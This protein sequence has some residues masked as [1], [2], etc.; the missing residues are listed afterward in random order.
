MQ[1][2]EPLVTAF[3]NARVRT[4]DPD[5]PHASALLVKDGLIEHVG[6]ADDIGAIASGATQVDCGGATV[7]PGFVDGHCHFE[8]TAVTTDAWINVHTPPHTSLAS[9]AG[10]I[11]SRIAN[12]TA[13]DWVLCRSSFAMHEKVVE[14]RLFNRHELDAIAADRP[15]AVFASLH[16]ASLNTV[17]LKRLALWEPDA[18]HPYHGLVHRDADGV[19]TGVVT[20]VFMMVPTPARGPAFDESV[21]RHARVQFNAA[22]TTS[23][24]TMPE[25]LD[26]IDRLRAL[27]R[28]HK[29]SLR[30]TYY[31]ISPGVANL[32]QA[33]ELRQL[34]GTGDTFR[35]GGVKVF[36]NGCG[37]DGL[38]VPHDDPKWTQSALNFF[39]RDAQS[40]G[41]QVWLHSLNPRGVRMAAEAI[42][43]ACGGGGN[44]LRHRIEHGGDFIDLAD[45]AA[46]RA[47]GAL[48][49]TTPQF[50]NSMTT[51]PTGPSAP[52]RTLRANGFRLIGGTDSTGTV[53]A[54]V[55]ILSNVATAATRRRH[56][57]TTFHPQEALDAESAVRL[58]TS[59]SSYGLHA[60]SRTGQLRKGMAADLVLVTDDPT[61]IPA[62]EISQV[63]VEATYLGGVQVWSSNV[64]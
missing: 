18:P 16:V 9:V 45:V 43:E 5:R 57:G 13:T 3:I 27:H 60:E 25:S 37:H 11:R 55:S 21:I 42:T 15:L 10:E 36:V 33:E 52:L 47:S 14:R 46:V 44:F 49:V 6:S 30:Q 63:A 58:F 61:Q 26:Q 48:L 32:D 22:G 51:D 29:L 31:V 39:V 28:D 34:D 20:E 64:T 59:E 40:R 17:A 1:V 23:V 50:L 62:T 12:D 8:L 24:G 2:D 41:L 7:L 19:P 56:D 54:S 35:F 4:L 53:P 38:G